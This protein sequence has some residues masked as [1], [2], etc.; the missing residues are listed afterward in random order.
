MAAMMCGASVDP[1]RMVEVRR[2]RLNGRFVGFFSDDPCAGKR[3]PCSLFRLDVILWLCGFLDM[4]N[5]SERIVAD[6][7]GSRM[8]FRL[9]WS[10]PW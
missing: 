8:A 3:L 4:T 6:L 1:D 10:P 9:W 5:T 2:M 7:E